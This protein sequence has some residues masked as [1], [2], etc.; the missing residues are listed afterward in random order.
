MQGIS[1]TLSRFLE[2]D[3]V[4]TAFYPLEPMAPPEGTPFLQ[5]MAVS[6]Y[7]QVELMA[8]TMKLSGE[9]YDLQWE[10]SEGMEGPKMAQCQ[11]P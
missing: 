3:F 1:T 6:N 5:T 7:G 9:V 11:V 8:E 10:V 2:T 4:H